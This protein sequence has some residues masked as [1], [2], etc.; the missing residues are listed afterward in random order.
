MIRKAKI[1]DIKR[2]QELINY[3]AGQDLMLPRSLNILYENLRDFFIYE[4]KNK[5][6]GCSALHISW[7]DL[8]EIKSLAVAKNYQNK[9]IGRKLAEACILEAKEI[10]AG[11]VFVLT[12]APDFFKK[13]GFRQTA[14]NKLP[15]KIWA[16][17]I[18]CPKFP[19]CRETALIKKI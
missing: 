6:V 14:H 2:I 17:C 13:L 18:N 19:D 4:D 1:G 15:H 5:I 8:A 9:G 12:Y 7:D 16:E 10:G 3:F 11:R